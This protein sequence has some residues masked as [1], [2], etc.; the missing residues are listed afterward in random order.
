M[1]KRKKPISITQYNDNSGSKLRVLGPIHLS[2]WGP[3][4]DAVLYLILSKNKET[5]Q[6]IYAGESDHTDDSAF[7]TKNEKFKCWHANAGGENN[8]H[9]CIYPMWNSTL[10]QRQRI[11]HKI[12]SKYNPICNADST[13]TE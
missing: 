12:I 6:I 9:L 13:N 11:S 5:F 1:Q 7:F 3:P 2:E 4:M 8:L 10:E